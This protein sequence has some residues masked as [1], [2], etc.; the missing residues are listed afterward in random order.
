MTKRAVP[1]LHMAMVSQS[2]N[3]GSYLHVDSRPDGTDKLAN[4]PV[5]TR[6]LQTLE[7]DRESCCSGIMGDIARIAWVG[8]I[9]SQCVTSDLRR[10]RGKRGHPGLEHLT[11]EFEWILADKDKV[12]GLE[13]GELIEEDAAADS[14]NEQT[15]L[16]HDHSEVGDTQDLGGNDAA[17]AD[18]ADPHDDAHHPH[19]AL[20]NN[21][22]ELNHSS[23]FGSQRS[24]N[25]SKGQTEED[26]SKGV[27][28]IPIRT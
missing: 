25:S 17:D 23:S 14:D 7:T 13:D 18:R 2:N 15:Q 20:V 6:L 4:P 9:I 19:D 12:D 28:S 24:K 21:S 26:D 5:H 3:D 27:G 8:Y 22:E 10:C 11:P 1:S 16:G